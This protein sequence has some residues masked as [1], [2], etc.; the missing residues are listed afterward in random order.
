MNKNTFPEGCF[1]YVHRR[2]DDG[3]IFYVGKAS[4]LKRCKSKTGRNIHWER[5][6]AKHGFHVEIVLSGLTNEDAC[7]NEQELIDFFGMENLTNKTLGGEGAP[8]VVI[9]EKQRRYMSELFKGKKPSENTRIAQIAACSKP[10]GTVCGLRFS[11]AREAV[12]HMRSLGFENACAA[13]ILSSLKGKSQKAY[14]FEWR[15]LLNDGTLSESKYKKPD[16][17]KVENDIGLSFDSANHAARW[18]ISQG[19]TKSDDVSS[20]ASNIASAARGKKGSVYA[21]GFRWRYLESPE[22]FRELGPKKGRKVLRSDGVLYV[23]L[24]EAAKA[25]PDE[26]GSYRTRLEKITQCCKGVRKE[27]LGFHWRYLDDKG[28]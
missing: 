24:V 8:G 19:H 15:Y 3:R 18:C 12:K 4:S 1:V 25:M 11:S 7:K 23:S 6:A 28:A 2:A 10:V 14:G 13:N 17:M 16:F 26:C 21:Y 9:S 20:C 22:G 27:A 5:V